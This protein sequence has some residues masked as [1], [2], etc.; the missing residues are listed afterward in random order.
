MLL[1]MTVLYFLKKDLPTNEFSYCHHQ[2][3]FTPTKYFRK[4]NNNIVVNQPFMKL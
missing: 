2:N 4:N 1:L 3:K